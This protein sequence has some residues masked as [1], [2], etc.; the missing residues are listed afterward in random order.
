MRKI[1]W[2]VA[3]FFLAALSACGGGGGSS[4]DQ[5]ANSVSR[6]SVLKFADGNSPYGINFDQ[7]KSAG[8]SQ[9][10]VFGGKLYAIWEES[11][12]T[13]YQIRVKVYDGSQWTWAD[14][15]SSSGINYDS[16]KNAGDPRMAVFGG[17]LYVAWEGA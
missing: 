7:T 16:S 9:P 2:A 8:D 17:K 13:A 12:G 6:T 4:S 10:A 11:N 14:G 5:A 1:F 15:G 3:I